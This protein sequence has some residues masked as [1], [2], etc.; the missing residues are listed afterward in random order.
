MCTHDGFRQQAA[1]FLPVGDRDAAGAAAGA[2][3][4]TSGGFD[5]NRLEKPGRSLVQL[6]CENC[7]MPFIPK[8]DPE[9][10][11]EASR[12]STSS[13]AT[14]ACT[15]PEKDVY[16]VETS[17]EAQA[18]AGGQGDEDEEEV[19]KTSS[20]LRGD[21]R[22]GRG[23]ETTA[24]T[25]KDECGGG[26]DGGR[27][28]GFVHESRRCQS[29]GDGAEKLSPGFCSGEC[30]MS[31]MLT[32]PAARRRQRAAAAANAAARAAFVESQ[33]Q[34]Q[35]QKQ[36]Q[37]QQQLLNSRKESTQAQQRPVRVVMACERDE[38]EDK[39]TVARD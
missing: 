32:N 19:V 8:V 14:S 20:A 36:Q 30:K 1:F 2:G 9:E 17:V 33:I 23:G 7:R 25:T 24:R 15:T 10:E 38:D 22:W 27:G 5:R 37:Q 3:V 31:Y 11:Q 16:G 4:A 29:T 34:K 26:E 6:T 39:A 13:G 21:Y 18:A 12:P 35:K 28:Q